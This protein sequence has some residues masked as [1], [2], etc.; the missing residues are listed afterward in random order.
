MISTDNFTKTLNT[1][2]DI[3]IINFLD[4]P[5]SC[6]VS[7]GCHAGQDL[8]TSYYRSQRGARAGAGGL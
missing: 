2:P 3:Y 5:R 7:G 6:F 1:T 8:P 4:R